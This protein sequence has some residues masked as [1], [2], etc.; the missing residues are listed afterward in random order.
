MTPTLVASR[1]ALPPEG[2]LA[3]GGGPAALVPAERPFGVGIIGVGNMGA[4]MAERLARLG[5]QPWVYDIIPAKAQNLERFGAVA[6]VDTTHIAIETVAIVICVVDAAQTREVLFGAQGIAPQLQPGQV[7]LLCPTISPQ[8]VEDIAQRL[9]AQ[10]VAVLDCPMSGGPVRA[11]EGSMSLMVAGADAAVE[12]CSALLNALSSQVFRISARVGDAARTKLVNNLLAG[13]NLVGAAEVL[14]LAGRLGLDQTRTLDV[15]AQSSGQSWIG[16][17]RMRRA[18]AGDLVPRAHM[19]LLAKDT[20]LAQ[21]C[22]RS[23]GFDSPLGA[24]ASQVFAAAVQAGLADLDDA[25]LLQFLE[26]PTT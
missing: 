23:V 16:L 25:A 8:D 7:V 20:G 13:I 22:A 10:G 18:V 14:A 3:P 19:T 15:I 11:R 4:A 26:H 21:D 5:W 6:L 9:R 12:S 1:T 2:A 17:D 24:L